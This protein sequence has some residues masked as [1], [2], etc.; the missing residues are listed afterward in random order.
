[1]L[2]AALIESGGDHRRA[3]AKL[4]QDDLHAAVAYRSEMSF[5]VEAVD[6]EALFASHLANDQKPFEKE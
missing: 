1:M 5:V 2:L 4:L 6:L 3:A